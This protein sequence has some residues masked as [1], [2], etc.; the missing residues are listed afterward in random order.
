MLLKE[1]I[2]Q[3]LL[4]SGALNQYI[5]DLIEKINL[6]EDKTNKSILDSLL[7]RAKKY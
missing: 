1:I 7:T 2:K 6:E 4:D 3:K 5:K